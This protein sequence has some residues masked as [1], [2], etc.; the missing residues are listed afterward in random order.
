MY[1]DS[2]IHR[3]NLSYTARFLATFEEL[4]PSMKPARFTND[5]VIQKMEEGFHGSN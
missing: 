5:N 4:P 3:V 2:V 1:Y